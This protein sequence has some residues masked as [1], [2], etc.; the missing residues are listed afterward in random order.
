MQKTKLGVIIPSR[1]LSFSRTMEELL[2][3]LEGLDYT[4]FFSVGRSLPECFN[5]PMD[6][7]LETDITHVLI[8]ED[9][10]II[11]KGILKKM[12]ALEYP[13]V[14]LDYPFKEEGQSTVLRD[15]DNWAFYTGTGF[16]LVDRI[17]F[18]KLPKPYFRTGIFWEMIIRRTGELEFWPYEVE[19]R[20]RYGL[21]DM[22]FGITMYSNKLPIYVMEE[23]AGQRKLGELGMVNSNNGQHH[24]YTITQV[25]KNNVITAPA[26]T[27]EHIR[28]LDAMNRI[29]S[30]KISTKKPDDVIYKDGK[31]Q[32]V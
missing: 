28:F 27:S 16:M 32:L 13:I 19:E 21:H 5:A 4:L 6:E 2:S 31:A 15:P 23:T 20:K 25:V 24:I 8:C 9:D 22:N 1:G 12:L 18:E 29:S 3:E 11:P 7:A 14:A 10:M 17:V 26:G 30:V